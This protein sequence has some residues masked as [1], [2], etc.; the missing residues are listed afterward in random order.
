MRRWLSFEKQL[1]Q[2]QALLEESEAA[3]RDNKVQLQNLGNRLNAALAKAAAE[4]R[5][6][7]KLEEEEEKGLKKSCWKKK[8]WQI[9]PWISQNI[10]RNFWS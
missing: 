6:R 7:R 5:R 2:L 3:D 9:R 4:E 8:N 10:S 1:G